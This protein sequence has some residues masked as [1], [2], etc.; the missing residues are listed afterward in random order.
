[1][2]SWYSKDLGDGVAAFGPSNKIQE[3]FL[4]LAEVRARSGQDYSKIAVFSHSDPGARRV[5]VYFSPN[6][7]LLAKAF[8]AEP[9][10]KPTPT[11][12]FSL[13]VGDANSWELFFPGYLN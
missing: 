1:M 9:C 3:A 5:T 12:G 2:E 4:A 13:L 8:E 6:A 11:D 10:A 7:E